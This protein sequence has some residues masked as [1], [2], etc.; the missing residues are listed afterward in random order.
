MEEDCPVCGKTCD[1]QG[2]ENHIRLTDGRGH[3]PA[4]WMPDRPDSSNRTVC[5]GTAG[6]PES[7]AS[8]INQPSAGANYD[9]LETNETIWTT[10]THRYRP[11]IF[12]GSYEEVWG[13]LVEVQRTDGNL[14][15]HLSVGT[16]LFP[17]ESVEAEICIAELDG[18]NGARVAILRT[19]DLD[20]PLRIKNLKSR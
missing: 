4:G 15:I 6:F 5:Q 8:L 19:D 12:L 7:A 2:L 13:R 10:T 17:I 11:R 1:T 3:G 18:S 20:R 16:L 14:A 9:T